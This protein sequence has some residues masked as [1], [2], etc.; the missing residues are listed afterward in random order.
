MIHTCSLLTSETVPS[1]QDEEDAEQENEGEDEE[2][3]GE[4]DED[5]AEG[6]CQPATRW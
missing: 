4:E 5:D 2:D 1:R 6:E 3:G